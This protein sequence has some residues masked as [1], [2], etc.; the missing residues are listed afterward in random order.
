MS[1]IKI[2]SIWLDNACC[3]ENGMGMVLNVDLNNGSSI[4]LCL[5]SKANEPLFCDVVRGKCGEPKTDGD[6]VYWE[7]GARLSLHDM[8]ATLQK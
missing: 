2:K 8:I 6:S 3:D 1:E 4:M 7:N 5:D